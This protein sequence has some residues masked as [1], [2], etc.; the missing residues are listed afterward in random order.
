MKKHM[1]FLFILFSYDSAQAVTLPYFE[2]FES[3]PNCGTTC[4]SACF[5]STTGWLND[6]VEDDREWTVD[7]DGTNSGGTGPVFD[8]TLGTSEGKY[9]YTETSPPCDM[10]TGVS[11]L[12]SP[13][14]ELTNT[15]NPHLRFYYHMFGED[16]GEL[17]IDILDSTMSILVTDFI[18]S[19]TDNLDEWQSVTVDLS[20]FIGQGDIF[21]RFRAVHSGKG[22]GGDMAL[23]D[24]SFFE[25]SDVIFADGFE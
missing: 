10:Q 15:T 16:M 22:F 7:S 6:A 25:L 3:E 18:P 17:H 24:V 9:L 1:A 8:H 4:G 12:I 20:K 2:D 19:I 11:N 13:I 14:I 23:D 5:L 21:I